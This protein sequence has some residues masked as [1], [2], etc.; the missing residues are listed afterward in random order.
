MPEISAIEMQRNDPDRVSILL[1]GHFAFGLTRAAAA[2]LKVGEDLGEERIRTLQAQDAR[3]RAYRQALLYLSF[4]PRSEA[5]IRKNLRKHLVLEPVIDETLERL[6]T[7]RFADDHEFAR[8]W[9]ENRS[10]F[11]PRGRQALTL[12]LRQKGIDED[13]IETAVAGVDEPALAYTAAAKRAPRLRNLSHDEFRKRLTD[14]LARRGFTYSVITEVVG[15]VWQ[16]TR[17]PESTLENE[18]P[19]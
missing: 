4:R 1:D 18:D 8:L 14:F 17:S 7:D 16:A 11:R 5:E 3:E 19:S 10:N 12:E 6:R 15:R 2:Q 9:V 13:T